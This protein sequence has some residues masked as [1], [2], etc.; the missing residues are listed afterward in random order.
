MISELRV[1]SGVI[2]FAIIEFIRGFPV[3][4]FLYICR[5]RNHPLFAFIRIPEL[6]P[7]VA[8]RTFSPPVHPSIRLLLLPGVRCK[9]AVDCGSLGSFWIY[10]WVLYYDEDSADCTEQIRPQPTVLLL[11]IPRMRPYLHHVVPDYLEWNL[12]GRALCPQTTSSAPSLNGSFFKYN[13]DRIIIPAL[14][15]Q[16]PFPRTSPSSSFA[17]NQGK[18]PRERSIISSSRGMVFYYQ[19]L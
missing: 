15:T 5:N 6:V 8:R 16:N 2:E 9:L 1:K 10:R 18:E 19:G 17:Y 12:F 11:Q 7:V 4:L 3:L 13:I 14:C